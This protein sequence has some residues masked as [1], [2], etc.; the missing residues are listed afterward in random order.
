MAAPGKPGWFAAGAVFE[1]Y[2][3]GIGSIGGIACDKYIAGGIKCNTPRV[4]VTCR[5]DI[6]GLAPDRR[7][8]IRI[9]G[10]QH[11]LGIVG[12]CGRPGNISFDA[13]IDYRNH[14]LGEVGGEGAPVLDPGAVEDVLGLGGGSGAGSYQ[15]INK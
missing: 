1:E 6:E 11:A 15:K 14:R 2:P 12:I 7:S 10:K 3:I 8:Y 5:I 13:A 9:F 4:G